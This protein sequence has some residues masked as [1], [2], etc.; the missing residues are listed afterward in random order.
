MLFEKLAKDEFKFKD[1]VVRLLDK[2]D[3]DPEMLSDK[4]EIDEFKFRFDNESVVK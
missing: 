2:P 4:L 1:S 3:T